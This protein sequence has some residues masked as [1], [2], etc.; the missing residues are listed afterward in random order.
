MLFPVTPK[1]LHRVELGG[2]SRKKLNLEAAA[3][4]K[5]EIVDQP[6]P[7]ASEP[8]PDHQHLASDVAQQV[9][10][11]PQGFERSEAVERFG[12]TQGRLTGT[13]GTGFYLR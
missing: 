8:V 2:I 1:V 4:S 10:E 6:A 12:R 7:M 11:L 5:D 13:G 9:F 3:L